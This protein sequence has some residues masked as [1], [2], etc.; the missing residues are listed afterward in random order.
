MSIE[1]SS[2]VSGIRSVADMRANAE[3][4]TRTEMDASDFLTLLTAQLQNQDPSSP[5]ENGEFLAQLAQMSSVQGMERLNETLGGVASTMSNSMISE[6]SSILGKS[7][8]VE[9]SVTRARGGEV[10]GR[11]HVPNDDSTVTLTYTDASTGEILHSQV[12]SNQLS[13]PMDFSWKEAPADD[14]KIRISATVNDL[15]GTI[16][17]STAVYAQVEGV[18]FDPISRDMTLQL[19]DYGAYLATEITALR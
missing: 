3:A 17:A 14:R 6:A 18:E 16:D 12:H 19:K 7:A 13:G 4:G 8:L 15:G 5:M 2:S 1:A 10:H 11:V 9:G